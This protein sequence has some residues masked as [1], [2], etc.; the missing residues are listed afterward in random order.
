VTLVNGGEE[1]GIRPLLKKSYN[2]T[3]SIPMKKQL[4]SLNAAPASAVFFYENLR[5]KRMQDIE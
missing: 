1:K 3:L 4:E 5:Q 2:V